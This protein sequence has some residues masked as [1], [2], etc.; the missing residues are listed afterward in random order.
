MDLQRHKI[1]WENISTN[2]ILNASF[3]DGTR[4]LEVF[5]FDY[6]KLFNKPNLNASCSKCIG[7][8]HKEYTQKMNA[9][10]NSSQYV[11]KK[12]YIGISLKST[13]SYKVNNNNITDEIGANLLKEKG[14]FLFE[15][16]PKRSEEKEVKKTTKKRKPTKE[17]SVE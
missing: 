11:L 13:P 8:Y 12:K 16:F 3:E 2:L 6:S 17:K 9:Q 7:A 10:N 1:E 14:S 15:K 5:L 4:Y